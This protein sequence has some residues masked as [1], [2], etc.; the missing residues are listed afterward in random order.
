MLAFEEAG[1]SANRP[2]IFVHGWCCHR[3]HMREVMSHFAAKHHVIAVDLPGH[4]ESPLGNASPSFDSFAASV[5]SFIS[6]HELHR[7]VLIGHSMG[8]VISVVAAARDPQL[9]AGVV[10]LDGAAPITALGRDGYRDLFSRI[11][12]EGFQPVVAEFIRKVFFL[13]FERGP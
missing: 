6:E 4:G 12:R 8:G 3:G 9:L 7:P 5:C 1:S 2:L 10:N 13:P 11:T